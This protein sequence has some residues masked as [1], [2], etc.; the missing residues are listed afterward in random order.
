MNEILTLIKDNGDRRQ[1]FAGLRSVGRTEFYQ[2]Q[3]V[4]YKP[5]LV[6]VLADYLDY[7]FESLVKYDGKLFRVLRTYRTGQE[8]EIVVT[9]ASAEEVALYGGDN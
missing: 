6:F 9:Q 7:D 3:A 8:L 2:A 5:E 1:V 4:G